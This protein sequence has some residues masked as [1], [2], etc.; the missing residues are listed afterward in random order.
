MNGGQAK[1]ESCLIAAAFMG[2]IFAQRT[3]RP[4]KQYVD[5]KDRIQTPQSRDTLNHSDRPTCLDKKEV[6]S[7]LSY[8]ENAPLKLLIYFV[9]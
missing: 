5:T 4:P 6:I 9:S 2:Y 7:L 8:V 1:P 3:P